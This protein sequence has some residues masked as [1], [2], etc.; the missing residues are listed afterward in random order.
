MIVIKTIS[1]DG[2]LEI[3]AV[4]LQMLE[5]IILEFNFCINLQ[6]IKRLP[7]FERLAKNVLVLYFG[8]SMSQR[9]E[10]QRFTPMMNT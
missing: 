1:G 2:R 4:S 5:S 7:K 9:V 8:V 3:V 10:I 6:L